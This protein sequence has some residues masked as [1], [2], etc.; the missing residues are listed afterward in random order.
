MNLKNLLNKIWPWFQREA[1]II[2]SW[3]LDPD[4]KKLL[5][6]IWTSLSPAIKSALIA[7]ITAIYKKYGADMTN[8]ILSEIASKLA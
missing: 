1:D 8:R 3:Q 2:E 6:T 5:D 4:V 7:F